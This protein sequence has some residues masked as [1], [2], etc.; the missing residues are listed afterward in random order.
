MR[1]ISPARSVHA[2]E[3]IAT[4]DN[5]Q[6]GNDFILPA[7]NN[8]FAV[9]EVSSST[10]HTWSSKAKGMGRREAAT[11]SKSGVF[12]PRHLYVCFRLG[13]SGGL[14]NARLRLPSS[15]SG[16]SSTRLRG[17]MVG[18][19]GTDVVTE[20]RR[21]RGQ[22]LRHWYVDRLDQWLRLL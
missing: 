8:H 15:R 17:L 13:G 18:G 2:S 7:R 16:R 1:E 20:L 14:Q 11:D 12:D 21:N 4:G 22:Q 6:A 10:G 19:N 3:T 9:P 5:T